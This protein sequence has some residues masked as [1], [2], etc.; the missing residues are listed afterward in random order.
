M[1]VYQFLMYRVELKVAWIRI[2]LAL[3]ISEFL[4]YR[5]ELKVVHILMGE[6][7]VFEFLMYRV[8]LKVQEASCRGPEG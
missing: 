3:R 5:V 6:S 1:S 7:V 2:H 4:M 8:E